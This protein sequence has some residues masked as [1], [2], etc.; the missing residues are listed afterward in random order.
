MQAQ[1]RV[2][3]QLGRG[4]ELDPEDALGAWGPGME[5]ESWQQE[6]AEALKEGMS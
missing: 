6:R 2:Q 4:W 1:P 5:A 3:S